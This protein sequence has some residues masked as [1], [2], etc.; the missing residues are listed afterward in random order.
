MICGTRF[1]NSSTYGRLVRARFQKP[2]A[3]E[4]PSGSSSRWLKNV[5][6]GMGWLCTILTM[7]WAK[8]VVRQAAQAKAKIDLQTMSMQSSNEGRLHPLL[9]CLRVTLQ[10][11]D[12]VPSITACLTH[13]TRQLNQARTKPKSNIH[14][15]QRACYVHVHV[16][17]RQMATKGT[18]GAEKPWVSGDSGP[19]KGMDFRRRKHM[20]ATWTRGRTASGVR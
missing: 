3:S 6:H 4:Q 14:S 13:L 9:A 18:R 19:S 7:G 10:S 17:G 1:L 15:Y 8:D 12:C 5:Q 2:G 20:M 16:N 11:L